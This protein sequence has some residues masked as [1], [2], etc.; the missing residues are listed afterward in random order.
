MSASVVEP[1]PVDAK[2]E[3]RDTGRPFD[4][5]GDR[6]TR[7]RQ[8]AHTALAVER[9]CGQ[10]EPRECEPRLDQRRHDV[11]KPPELAE[12]LHGRHDVE[13]HAAAEIYRKTRISERREMIHLHRAEPVERRLAQTARAG[14]IT[15][16]TT[17]T[18]WPQ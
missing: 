17:A 3:M 11:A 2:A 9:R 7:R 1:S 10:I 5:R 12:H 4:I 8:Q 16:L 15:T 18:S 13:R 14:T 6:R